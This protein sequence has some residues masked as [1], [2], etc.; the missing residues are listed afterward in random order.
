MTDDAGAVDALFLVNQACP[1]ST[2]ASICANS[3]FKR[4]LIVATC[5]LFGFEVSILRDEAP[6]TQ[7]LITTVSDWLT[8]EEMERCD[9]AATL[10]LASRLH[11]PGLLIAYAR[12]F[13]T[14]SLDRKNALLLEKVSRSYK[15]RQAFY[16]E[17]LGVS[18]NVWRRV[19]RRIGGHGSV[20]TR[21]AASLAGSILRVFVLA[22][23]LL[24][25]T[26]LEVVQW[27][28]RT[29]LFTS[30]RRIPLN[31]RVAVGRRTLGFI[32]KLSLCARCWSIRVPRILREGFPDAILATT[33]H[34]FPA[35][36]AD[37][38]GSFLVFLDGFHPSNYPRTYLDQYGACSFAA[39][40]PLSVEWFRR[41]GCRV[42]PA[43]GFVLAEPM[44]EPLPMRVRG[45]LLA[46]NHAGDWT[47]LINRSDT[48]ALVDAFCAVAEKLPEVEFVVRPHPTM[49]DP[50]HEGAGSKERLLRR[51]ECAGLHN[52]RVSRDSLEDDLAANEVVVSEYS[53]VLID[54]YR[55]GKL[56]LIVNVTGRRSFM[57]DYESL[58]FASVTD[59]ES[60]LE[61]LRAVAMDPDQMLRRQSAAVAAYNQAQLEWMQSE[62][63]RNEGGI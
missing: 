24:R 61:W 33:I 19:G 8:D 59:E 38:E 47:S 57:S 5:R 16:F 62:R 22:K 27:G 39:V 51:V 12:I 45:V 7:F 18:G 34:R 60:M 53:Q 40:D 13:S 25:S 10:Q 58:G 2:V 3:A 48:D 50:A 32:E 21:S 52:L 36:M 63:G 14:N 56:G 46:L 9:A 1:P 30:T 26:V 44:R 17:G 23:F 31:P 6:T 49:D 41:H 43:P 55:Q 20:A 15:W 29:Y 28:G 4:V 11:E 42:I 35:W 54:A 37:E